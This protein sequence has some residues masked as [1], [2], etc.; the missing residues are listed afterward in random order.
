M[1]RGT[2]VESRKR[3]V[4]REKERAIDVSSKNLVFN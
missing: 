1:N 3:N 4:E 2:A